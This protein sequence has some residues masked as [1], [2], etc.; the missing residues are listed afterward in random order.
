MTRIED[1]E[2]YE[3]W[4]AIVTKINRR[5]DASP[6]SLSD[7]SRLTDLNECTIRSFIPFTH[8]K[9]VMVKGKPA[10]IEGK[11]HK[12]TNRQKLILILEASKRFYDKEWM[13]IKD[14]KEAIKSLFPDQAKDVDYMVN[15]LSQLYKE[16]KVDRRGAH[17]NFE[18]SVA[19]KTR[20][21]INPTATMADQL[22]AIATK[23]EQLEARN[24][25]LEKENAE[26]KRWKQK[27][28]SM[29]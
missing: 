17:R 22:I 14:I 23:I 25:E 6:K 8:A 3:N 2:N 27:I 24:S 13:R 7:L 11:E 20:R 26:L 12:V 15:Q 21:A 4:G 5:L 1:T 16:G 18:Y 19:D 28:L 29:D 9:E 10:Y